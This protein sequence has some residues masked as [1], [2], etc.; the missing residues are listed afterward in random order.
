MA[1]TQD[2]FNAITENMEADLEGQGYFI[3]VYTAVG[4]FHGAFRCLHNK[5]GQPLIAIDLAQQMGVAK[6]AQPDV[7]IPL[8]D[9]QAI[10]GPFL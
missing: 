9:I 3:R 1:M 2:Q 4:V 7:F 6:S 5:P 10:E 8:S